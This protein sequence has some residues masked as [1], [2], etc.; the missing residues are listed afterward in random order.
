MSDFES[1]VRANLTHMGNTLGDIHARVIRHDVEIADT[2]H[3]ITALQRLWRLRG[4]D[5]RSNG[6]G[7]SNNSDPPTSASI[8]A[9]A[10]GLERYRAPSGTFRLSDGELDKLVADIHRKEAFERWTGVK[11]LALKILAPVVAAGL[12]ALVGFLL[13]V[14]LR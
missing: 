12:I 11:N 8:A 2:K 7:N 9:S 3:D 1:F 13:H 14:V 5:R 10:F 4:N 6:G